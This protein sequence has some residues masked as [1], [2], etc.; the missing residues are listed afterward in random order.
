MGLDGWLSDEGH[1]YP[2]KVQYEDTDAGGVVYHANYLAFAERARSAWFSLI[3]IEAAAFVVAALEVRYH[4][5]ARLGQELRVVSQLSRM[6]GVRAIM[7]Q[8]ITDAHDHL[9][10]HIHVQIVQASLGGRPCRFD[11]DVKT[12]ILATMPPQNH[13][14]TVSAKPALS[15]K[16][17]H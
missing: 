8:N 17:G 14:I 2:L 12:K 13:E 6:T 4:R 3:G 5:P 1:I 16:R 15:H 10:T 9:L 7:D 11:P